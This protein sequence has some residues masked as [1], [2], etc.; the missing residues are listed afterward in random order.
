LITNER[1]EVAFVLALVAAS[2]PGSDMLKKQKP[3]LKMLVKRS[4]R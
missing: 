4:I 1:A 2:K 3:E